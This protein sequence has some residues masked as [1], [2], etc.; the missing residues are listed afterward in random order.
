MKEKH[1]K[2]N[3]RPGEFVGMP[4]SRH[5]ESESNAFLLE[6][7]LRHPTPD[8]LVLIYWYWYILGFSDNILNLKTN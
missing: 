8:R 6:M 2:S 1:R 7:I 3:L 5:R 4:F